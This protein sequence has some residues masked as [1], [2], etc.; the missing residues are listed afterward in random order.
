MEGD[1]RLGEW[2]I[3]PS[4]GRVSLG[5]ETVPLRAKAMDLLVCLARNPGRVVSKD[6]ILDEVWAGSFVSES[7]LTRVVTD[8][9]H[10]LRDDVDH[11]TLIETIPK[12]GYRLIAPLAP[13]ADLTPADAPV[14]HGVAATA[15]VAPLADRPERSDPYET[16][17]AASEHAG[18]SPASRRRGSD[19]ARAQPGDRRTRRRALTGAAAIAAVLIAM[20]AIAR[21]GLERTESGWR[22]PLLN[23]RFQTVTDF[24]GTEQG[25]AIS[26]DGKFVAFFSDREG[27]VDVW[28]TQLGSGQ[29]YNLTRGRAPG[30]DIVNP[31]V[32]TLAF[33][34]DGTLVTFWAR[35]PA[36]EIS[37]WA[38]PTLGGQAR[39]YLE[40]AAEFDWSSD[41]TKLV[42]HTPGPGD[43]MFVEIAGA[44]GATTPIFSAAAGLH[45][46]FPLWS[47]DAAF[48]YFVQ[49][50]PSDEM[51]I[52]R[53]K[54]NG[55]AAERVT[56]H[57]SRVSY[58]VWLDGRTLLYLATDADGSGPWLHAIDVDRPV[59]HRVSEGVDRYTSLAA[60]ADR[61]RLAVTLASPNGTLWRLRLGNAATES[62]AATPISLTTGRGFS[63]RVGP[64]FL[65]YVSSDAASDRIWKLADGSASELWSAPSARI[66]GGPELAS[67]GQRVAF[68]VAQQGRTALYVMNADGTNARVVTGALQLRGA[69][70]WAPNGQSIA[71]AAEVDG[72]PRLFRIALDGA[73]APLT[74]DYALDPV[75]SPSGDFLVYSGA[76]V[77]TTFPVKAVTTAGTPHPVPK[78]MLTRGA[79]RLRF[80]RG[81]RALVL[82]RG[83]MQ[84]TDLSLVDLDTGAEHQLTRLGADFNIRDFDV[85]PDGSEVVLE[86]VQQRSEIV[87]IDL[88]RPE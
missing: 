68:S 40:G 11:P 55:G 25:A 82:M 14:P 7:A 57:N 65:L 60:S 30:L 41:G 58:P 79:R 10:A 76:D 52:W 18:E 64:G 88:A 49:G 87:L 42:Y 16:E 27:Q 1:F 35:N 70:A 45:A 47:P 9:R 33:S 34:P 3:Q 71:S 73:A 86:R 20:L 31:S 77:G 46:H 2:L 54:P 32:R 44:N 37:I 59:A 26:R 72:T 67:D 21:W 80:V 43:P 74:S 36:G 48:I 63:P 22:N 24:G 12:R 23:A 78:L 13:A 8:L 39:P 66:I 29:F 15:A 5:S 56:H 69:P 50:S 51:D 81:N 6:Q 19:D 62:S 28:V 17:T 85:A 75:W 38:V 84:H 4:L 61:R 83:D 53:I